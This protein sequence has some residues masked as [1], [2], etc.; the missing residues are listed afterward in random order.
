M[1]MCWKFSLSCQA[2]FHR[3]FAIFHG[4]SLSLLFTRVYVSCQQA[5]RH[6]KEG[7]YKKMECGKLTAKLRDAVPVCFMVNDREVKRYK[8]IEIPAEI[9]HL[10]YCGFRFDVPEDGGAITFKIWPAEQ[11]RQHRTVKAEPVA[12][13]E[14]RY[15]VAAR[16]VKRWWQSSAPSRESTPGISEYLHRGI[17]LAA[18]W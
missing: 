7:R 11:E 12:M 13:M 15:G 10:E 18:A 17:R 8:N 4:L 3:D 14:Q 1:R 2:V 16:T 9:K 5:A 6:N